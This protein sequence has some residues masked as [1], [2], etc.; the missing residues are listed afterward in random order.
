MRQRKMWSRLFV[1]A[2]GV[3]ALSATASAQYQPAVPPVPPALVQPV[4]MP[5]GQP[6]V[7]PPPVV[8]QPG[9]PAPAVVVPGNGGCN[10]C[11]TANR[12]YTMSGGYA[13]SNCQYGNTKCNNGCGS[14]K[15]D[16]AFFFGS[17]K[18]F[19]DPC[20][21]TVGG[22][23]GGFGHGRGCGGGLFG[24]HCPGAPILGRGPAGPFNPCVYDS[25]ANH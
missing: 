18:S 21:P 13:G 24:G 23:G 17:C 9:A 15:A 4:N 6:P 11:G 7:A 1:A 25:Y 8:V 3:F 20:G 12:G 16:H 5:I 19:F 2:A 10:G 22:H 14:C